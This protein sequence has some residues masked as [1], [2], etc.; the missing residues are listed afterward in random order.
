LYAS[1]L[2]FAP[3]GSLVK[4]AFQHCLP[5]WL[6]QP[7][8]TAQTWRTD[9]L[10]IEAHGH[11]TAMEFSPDDRYIATC[12]DDGTT[13]IWDSNTGVCLSTSKALQEHKSSQ[14][15]AFSSCNSLAVAS[16]SKRGGKDP[17]AAQTFKILISRTIELRDIAEVTCTALP[18][19]MEKVAFSP[20]D[21]DVLY[22]AISRQT[23]GTWTLDMWRFVIGAGTS[24]CIWSRT[25][26][27]HFVVL[28][29]SAEVGLVA[30]CLDNNDLDIADLHSG[31]S[32][33]QF[34]MM[35]IPGGLYSRDFCAV[36][37]E[38]LIIAESIRGKKHPPHCLHKFSMQTGVRQ[39]FYNSAEFCHTFAI[40]HRGDRLIWAPSGG[41]F[42]EVR[43]MS[44]PQEIAV[45]T[46]P[47]RDSLVDLS[48]SCNGEML[49]VAYPDRIEVQT[50]RGDIIF[51]RPVIWSTGEVG[52]LYAPRIS[53]SQD[54][55]FIAARTCTD[56]G[57]NGITLWHIATGKEVHRPCNS[58]G[59]LAPVF[60]HSTGV[61]AYEDDDR[62]RLV[63]WDILGD[64][65]TRTFN[66]PWRISRS[67]DEIQF[68]PDDKTLLT[69]AGYI[70]I[71]DESEVWI[72]KAI[73]MYLPN[74]STSRIHYREGWVMYDRQ[75]QIWVPPYYRPNVRRAQKDTYSF[76]FGTASGTVALWNTDS[77]VVMRISDP[78]ES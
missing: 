71:A 29:I 2:A 4:A 60:S 59:W 8:V 73:S 1:A 14:A 52:Y 50:L 3:Q 69:R 65:G 24:D 27:D 56:T 55:A 37:G 32:R 6:L 47:Q 12:S 18:G 10:R 76:S 7:P 36:H 67:M 54:G 38:N 75:D 39:S 16:A 22:A 13:R 20:D 66:V 48:L 46:L 33:R 15:L 51:T 64:I 58:H 74:R 26:D 19:Y 9:A 35:T 68:S 28:G 42:V 25:M 5:S 11:F 23:G 34:N 31:T 21:H 61:L 63:V 78:S 40:A 70:R 77:L 17:G 53:S 30:C 62:R 41:M 45:N 57:A 72:D 44:V 43:S 49:L